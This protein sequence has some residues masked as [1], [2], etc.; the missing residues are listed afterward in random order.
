MVTAPLM[1]DVGDISWNLSEIQLD[2]LGENR[3]K[4]P[5][6]ACRDDALVVK[7]VT[8]CDCFVISP[9]LTAHLISNQFLAGFHRIF[10]V[11]WCLQVAI[12]TLKN[13]VYR[14]CQQIDPTFD[15]QGHA[16]R[17]NH[18]ALCATSLRESTWC[19]MRYWLCVMHVMRYALCTDI[20]WCI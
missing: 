20:R 11:K 8:N 19:V 4:N 10:R 2:F 7:L 3:G 13:R 18:Y 9:G 5:S 17:R 14:K 12:L 6:I 16:S 15:S 1:L